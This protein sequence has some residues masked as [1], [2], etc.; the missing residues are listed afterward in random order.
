MPVVRVRSGQAISPIYVTA[1]AGC[2]G[3][4]Y[5]LMVTGGYRRADATEDGGTTHLRCT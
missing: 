1:K 5:Q 4:G 3:G 2:T